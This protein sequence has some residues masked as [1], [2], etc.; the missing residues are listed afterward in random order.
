MLTV[1]G[2]H[3]DYIFIFYKDGYK[4]KVKTDMDFATGSNL[5][6]NVFFS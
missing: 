5:V 4:F 1:S 6:K 2:N 3:S